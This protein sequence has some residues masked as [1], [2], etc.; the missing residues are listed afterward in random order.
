MAPSQS[1]DGCIVDDISGASADFEKA[2][3]DIPRMIDGRT[4]FLKKIF[5]IT[6]TQ[7]SMQHWLCTFCWPYWSRRSIEA[8]KVQELQTKHLRLK[9]GARHWIRKYFR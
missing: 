9:K 5:L 1:R 3:K 7:W 6:L 4:I 8:L 2:K